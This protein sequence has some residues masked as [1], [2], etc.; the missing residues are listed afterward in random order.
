MK[1]AEVFL[2]TLNDLKYPELCHLQSTD[3]HLRTFLFLKRLLTIR[4][5]S[6]T[7]KD[8]KCLQ[9]LLS[10][11]WSQNYVL[12]DGVVEEDGVLRDDADGLPERGLGHLSDV[13]VVNQ[14]RAFLK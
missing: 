3:V 5:S 12:P 6:K 8:L 10:M 4:K 2:T 7:L 1:W 14:N 13:L 11:R 9:I